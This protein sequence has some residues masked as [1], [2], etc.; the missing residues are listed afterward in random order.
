VFIIIWCR[1][2]ICGDMPAVGDFI[3]PFVLIGPGP[4]PDCHLRMR[5]SHMGHRA[6]QVAFASGWRGQT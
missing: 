4:P 3:M 2:L 6:G 5:A 1:I